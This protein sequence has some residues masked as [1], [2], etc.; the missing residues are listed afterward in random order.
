MTNIRRAYLKDGQR[1]CRENDFSA[2]RPET[3]VRRCSDGVRRPGSSVRDGTAVSVNGSYVHDYSYRLVFGPYTTR[4][5]PMDYEAWLLKEALE[6]LVPFRD[7][8]EVEEDGSDWLVTYPYTAGDVPAPL[9]E[10]SSALNFLNGSNVTVASRGGR[11]G[12]RA[13]H[14]DWRS[15]AVWE[16]LIRCMSWARNGVYTPTTLLRMKCVRRSMLCWTTSYMA[17]RRS[18]NELPYMATILSQEPGTGTGA[19]GA[20][21]TILVL[22]MPVGRPLAVRC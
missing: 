15:K 18:G 13:A 7:G 12:H 22:S 2:E 8:V 16:D 17:G 19:I 1:F 21:G 6:E 4:S 11:A 9:T 10:A 20:E 3:L 5:L 14:L